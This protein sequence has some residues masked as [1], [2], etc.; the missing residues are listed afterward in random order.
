MLYNQYRMKPE[1]CEYPNKKF[2]EGKLKSVPVCSNAIKPSIKPYLLFNLKSENE[3]T[4]EYVNK[5]EV[6]FIN[7][8]LQNLLSSVKTTKY[9]IGIITPYKA[10]KMLLRESIPKI[11]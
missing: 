4:S 7:I 8:L 5:D 10:Q 9:T 11:K 6:A 3:D 2:Y 1:I